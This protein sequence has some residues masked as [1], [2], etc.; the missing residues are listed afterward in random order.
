MFRLDEDGELQPAATYPFPYIWLALFVPYF[1]SWVY[2]PN[3]M[4]PLYIIDFPHEL[5]LI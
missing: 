5:I 3:S 2:K 4:L 1:V